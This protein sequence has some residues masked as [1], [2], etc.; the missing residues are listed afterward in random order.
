MLKPIITALAIATAGLTISA[1]SAEAACGSNRYGAEVC[2]THTHD[3]SYEVVVDDKY[4]S[5]GY[6]MFV[7]CN[8]GAWR[9]RSVTGYD[10]AMLNT[11][12]GKVCE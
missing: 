7:N 3:N 11:E 1:A 4:D 8:N 6:I 5:T 9:A 12:A 10:K 2:I